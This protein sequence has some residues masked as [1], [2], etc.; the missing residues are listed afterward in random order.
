MRFHGTRHTAATM[1]LVAPIDTKVVSEQLGHSSTRVTTDIYQHVRH[2]LR[3]DA[4]ARVG[5]LLRKAAE[6]AGS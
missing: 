6:G 3:D 4:A 5:D 2:E 1:M